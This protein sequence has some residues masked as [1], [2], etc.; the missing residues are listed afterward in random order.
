MIV[1]YRSLSA[2]TVPEN[3][4]CRL[5]SKYR[6]FVEYLNDSIV[7]FFESTKFM[8]KKLLR[9]LI[10]LVA[11]IGLA[12][13]L[14]AAGDD[15][16]TD[17]KAA[18]ATAKAE[19]KPVLVDFTGSDWCGWCIRLDKEV[20]SKQAFKDYAKES[21]VLLEIDFPRGIEQSPALEAQNE[22]L[23][24]KYKV[25]GFPTILLLSGDGEV[26]GRTGYQK[27][28]AEAYVAHLKELLN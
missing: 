10:P 21:L 1:P 6:C 4:G 23:A 5:I 9:S 27:G 7:L 24:A 13:Q 20:F 15:W 22:A 28:G 18:L 3:R 19:N 14:Q 25:R 8:M 11:F 17:F 26:L 16:Q 2:L 12:L